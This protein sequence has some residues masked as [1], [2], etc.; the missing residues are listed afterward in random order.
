MY[1]GHAV[2]INM[3]TQKPEWTPEEKLF[4]AMSA[5]DFSG[6]LHPHRYNEGARSELDYAKKASE[7][8]EEEFL[9]GKLKG[10]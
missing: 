1:P 4:Q 10:R 8:L 7:T 9:A 3:A 6:D 2:Q 5:S